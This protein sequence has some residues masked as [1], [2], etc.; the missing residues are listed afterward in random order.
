M[1]EISVIGG[2]LFFALITNIIFLSNDE[3]EM[4]KSYDER[5]SNIKFYKK[6]SNTDTWRTGTRALELGA[7]MPYNT[8]IHT[9]TWWLK[10]QSPKNNLMNFGILWNIL[11]ELLDMEIDSKFLEE[12]IGVKFIWNA[13]NNLVPF[14]N[15]QKT[16]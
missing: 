10:P 3:F 7:L 1:F 13:Q 15:R 5:K 6:T 8:L 11:L 4:D 14:Y 16:L 12:E 9:K 2:F